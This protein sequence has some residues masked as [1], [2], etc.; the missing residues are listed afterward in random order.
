M[1]PSLSLLPTDRLVDATLLLFSVWSRKQSL[2]RHVYIAD[3]AMTASHSDRPEL[4]LRFSHYLA[5]LLGAILP[6]P[7]NCAC[8]CP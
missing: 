5:Q 8:Q 2:Q 1:S 6:A 3:R 7:Q 4:P